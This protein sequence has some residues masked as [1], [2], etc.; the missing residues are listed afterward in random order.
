VT[1]CRVIAISTLLSRIAIGACA[2]QKA[3]RVPAAPEPVRHEVAAPCPASLDDLDAWLHA[4][5]RDREVEPLSVPKPGDEFRYLDRAL[6]TM[7]LVKL[8]ASSCPLTTGGALVLTSRRLAL[9]DTSA[10][11]G[12]PAA[13]A[14]LLGRKDLRGLSPRV[15]GGGHGGSFWVQPLGL[16]IEESVRW[17]D[18]A[19]VLEALGRAGYGPINV[20]FS[21]ATGH[22]SPPPE[23]EA[24]RRFV[25]IATSQDEMPWERL[26][27][28]AR[29]LE[30]M[31]PRCPA[32][33]DPV[34]AV[35][36]D[37]TDIEVQR[38]EFVSQAASLARGC[39]CD[40]VDIPSVKAFAWTRFGREWGP[41]TTFVSVDNVREGD[42]LGHAQ[43]IA[44]PAGTPWREA[45]RAVLDA[46]KDRDTKLSFVVRP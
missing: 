21:T 19:H 5:E 4:L 25:A 36:A 8:D 11:V 9:A 45:Y 17:V 46:A 18:V 41:L 39:G 1:S 6:P 26:V 10:D 15:G 44:L 20:V 37:S 3:L 42:S 2:A 33:A 30:E 23:S 13:V 31:H 29:T 38:A 16:F 22:A 28:A 40:A 35:P 7:S 34:R 27:R 12:D 43:A 32:L 14:A 24:L